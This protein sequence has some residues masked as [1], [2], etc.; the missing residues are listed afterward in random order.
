VETPVRLPVPA[1]EAYIDAEP[2]G[3][4]YLRTSPEFAM[5]RL[6]AD[7]LTRIYQLGPCFRRGEWGEHHRPEFTMLEWYRVGADYLDMLAETKALLAAVA[8]D[9]LG[10]LSWVHG[11]GRIELMPV[12]DSL[13]VDEAFLQF[14]GWSPVRAFD[15]DRFDRDTVEKVEPALSRE[16][17][18]VLRDYP[19][20]A[21]AMARLKPGDP[22]VAERW[23]IYIGGLEVANAFS[24]LTD[25]AECRRR[26]AAWSD[27][28]KREGRE[29]YALDEAFLA[30]MDKGLPGCAG[31]ALG[32]DR[33]VMLLAN[34]ADIGNVRME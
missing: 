24:E 13:T 27:L 18:T 7:G 20:E 12:W 10:K 29:V 17:P 1:L 5:K 3:T 32:V 30:A 31:V 8:K 23:E 6:L 9:V 33:L 22:R 26:F 28:R 21:A 11:G 2:S 34:E 19:A 16:R 25:S 15:A 14:A 4:A